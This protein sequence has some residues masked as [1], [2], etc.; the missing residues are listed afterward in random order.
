MEN[1]KLLVEI[2]DNPQSLSYGL[3]HRQELAD[4]QGM[5]FQ[6]PY[7][8]EASFWGKNTYIPLDVAF[9][10]KNNEIIDVKN[11]TPL[12]TK[13]VRSEGFCNMAI[14]ANFGFF[15]K[16]NIKKG[17]KVKIIKVSDSKF[18]EVEFYD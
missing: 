2:A 8:L 4:N 16:N 14:E 13:L 11:I 6:F 7:S 9:V 17:S 5:L 3:M 18:H 12:S 15:S 1:R 10:N